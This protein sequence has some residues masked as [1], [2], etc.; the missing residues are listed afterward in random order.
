VVPLYQHVRFLVVEVPALAT[1]L[2][3]RLGEQL[4]RL[5]AP[6]H[7][8]LA[9][10]QIGFGV[11][12]TA[13]GVDHRAVR[14]GG[15]RGQPQ[16]STGLLA[17]RLQWL[18]WYLGTGD[19]RI[20]AVGLPADRDRFGGA[21]HWAA[22]PHCDSPDFGQHQEAIIQSGAILELGIGETVVAIA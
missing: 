19:T 9:A 16:V 12:I 21:L 14:E 17:G 4:H 3:M 10:P 1:D 20:P 22:P 8:A 13:R 5:L 7:S 18:R 6:G 2:L 15:K 11:A